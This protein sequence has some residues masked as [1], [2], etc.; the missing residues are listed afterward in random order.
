MMEILLRIANAYIQCGWIANPAERPR[1]SFVRIPMPFVRI[2]NP[3]A[4]NIS[5]CN[6]R[7]PRLRR[8]ARK[9]RLRMTTLL[10]AMLM[11]LGAGA[12]SMK[13]RVYV[14]EDIMNQDGQQSNVDA[15][16]RLE[17][18]SDTEARLTPSIKAKPDANFM[19]KIGLKMAQKKMAKA[20]AKKPLLKYTVSNGVITVVGGGKKGKGDVVYTIK[21][22]GNSLRCN[23]G[24]KTYTLKR[25]K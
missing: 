16:V 7:K 6:A 15:T 17:F 9:P 21:D 24:E 13:G 11:T 12:Q 10:V 23:D 3:H 5:I 14:G 1:C 18:V 20:V 8:N 19:M 25:K 2:C 4:P 22:G